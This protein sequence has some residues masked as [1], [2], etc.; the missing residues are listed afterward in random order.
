MRSRDVD[1]K[2]LTPGINTPGDGKSGQPNFTRE[3][4]TTDQ[5]EVKPSGYLFETIPD[6]LSSFDQIIQNNTIDSNVQY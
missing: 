3:I 2:R 5:S 4:V 6:Q 1:S